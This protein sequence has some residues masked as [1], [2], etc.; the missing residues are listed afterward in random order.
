M[1]DV[2]QPVDA[3]DVVFATIDGVADDAVTQLVLGPPHAAPHR[4]GP[5]AA[6]LEAGEAGGAV[7]ARRKVVGG[8]P[9]PRRAAPWP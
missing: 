7:V 2:R 1:G 6:Q 4:G 3:V 8:G 9:P 5:G